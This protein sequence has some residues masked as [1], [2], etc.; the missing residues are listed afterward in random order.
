MQQWTVANE[1]YAVALEDPG[2]AL[3]RAYGAPSAVAFDLEWY[4][5]EGPTPIDAGFTQRGVVHGI[6]E[7]PGGALRLEEEPA[8]RWRRWADRLVPLPLPPAYAHTGTRTAFAF[9]DGSFA[10]WVLTPDGWRGLETGAS[11]SGRV[12]QR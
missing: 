1:T 8:Q 12:V 4:A 11:A 9:P 3:G 10:D 6:I 5:T 2:E 7:L